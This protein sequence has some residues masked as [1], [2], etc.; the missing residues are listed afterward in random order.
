[1]SHLGDV[2]A[3]S[4]E[5]VVRLHVQVG[6]RQRVHEVKGATDLGSKGAFRG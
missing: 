3:F 5:D 4:D 1:V 2:D 6:H